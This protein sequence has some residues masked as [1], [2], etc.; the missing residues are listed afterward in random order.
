MINWRRAGSR[1]DGGKV[2]IDYLLSVQTA[3]HG[4]T[5][6]PF[7]QEAVEI[8]QRVY[9]NPRVTQA[10]CIAGLAIQHPCR[11]DDDLAM[12][13]DNMGDSAGRTLLCIL[14][15]NRALEIRVPPI[16]DDDVASGMGRMSARFVLVVRIGFLPGPIA[17]ESA[18]PPC[19]PCWK[20]PNSTV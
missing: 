20:Q 1:V 18:P 4:M 19:I 2:F 3:Q 8:G 12:G 17:A 11:H 6:P 5:K 14:A 9:G 7:D 16:P 10:E 13:H 15:P